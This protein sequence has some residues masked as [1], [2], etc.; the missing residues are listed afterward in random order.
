MCLSL[1]LLVVDYCQDLVGRKLSL[2]PVGEEVTMVTWEELEQAIT[3]G[4]RASQAVNKLGGGGPGPW[5]RV[6]LP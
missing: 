2:M 3:D 5:S 1:C 4:W 6:G